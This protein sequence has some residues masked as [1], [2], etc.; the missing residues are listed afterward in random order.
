[1]T[2]KSQHISLCES[3]KGL[4]LPVD[5][6]Q[7]GRKFGAVLFMVSDALTTLSVTRTV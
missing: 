4:V 5:A 1:M 7:A 2:P 3:V 6:A